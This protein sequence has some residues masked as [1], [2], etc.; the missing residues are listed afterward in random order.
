MLTDK[1]NSE[2]I[3]IAERTVSKIITL[4]IRAKK[5][6]LLLGDTVNEDGLLTLKPHFR[7]NNTYTGQVIPNLTFN[8]KMNDSF[9][10]EL[11][12]SFCTNPKARQKIAPNIS[13]DVEDK[14]LA[15]MG[16]KYGVKPVKD[17]AAI[18][19]EDV[20]DLDGSCNEPRSRS[21]QLSS[22][23]V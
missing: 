19:K 21:H 16:T 11:G 18:R 5:Q 1:L 15:Y 7:Y 17:D 8:C 23:L 22:Q 9:K 2:G 12:K 20:T 14:I 3:V 13:K 4:Y 6:A 10:N